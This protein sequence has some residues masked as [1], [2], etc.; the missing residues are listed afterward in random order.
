MAEKP[1][2]SFRKRL[3]R[4]KLSIAGLLLVCLLFVVGAF[5]PYISPYNPKEMMYDSVFH[6][7]SGRFLFGTDAF[8]RDLL[9]RVIWG[10]RT[11]LIIGLGAT[12]LALIVGVV[13]GAI[14]GY[15]GGKISQVFMRLADIQLCIPRL[16]LLI[17]IASVLA[18]RG[19]M[20]IT[21]IIGIGMWPRLGRITRSKI[22]DIKTRD[23][24]EA[25]RA[26]GASDMRIILKHVF[27]NVIGPIVVI[28][29]LSAGSAIV[30][31]AGL[32][33]L[34]LGDPRTISWGTMLSEGME[35]MVVAPWIS[36]FPGLAIFLVVW[37]LNMFGDALRDALDVE[38]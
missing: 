26:L 28:T 6:P 3:L 23:F 12:S 8:G 13:F 27:P 24:V 22:L 34:G 14:A 17:V 32:S 19:L 11:S 37:G 10:A 21:A 30:S 33:F 2:R 25:A 20:I 5:A 31:E 29:T 18:K 36:I 7:P 35:E 38:N 1:S 9:S 15:Y 4:N 16:I